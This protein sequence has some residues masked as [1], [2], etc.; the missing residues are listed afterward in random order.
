MPLTHTTASDLIAQLPKFFCFYLDVCFKTDWQ[1]SFPVS[2]CSMY[3][4]SLSLWGCGCSFNDSSLKI[5]KQWIQKQFTRIKYTYKYVYTFFQMSN[6][7]L[8]VNEKNVHIFRIR[9]V[10]M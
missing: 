9:H 7:F 8:S 1:V 6:L 3:C 5:L 4:V 2:T 10:S